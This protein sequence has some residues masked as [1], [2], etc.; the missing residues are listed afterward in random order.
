MKSASLWIWLAAALLAAVP[1]ARAETSRLWGRGGELWTPA[2]RLPD[3]SRAGYGAG[4]R[5]I[6]DVPVA[7]NVRDFGAAGDGL[8]D[9]S[10]AFQRALASAPA[11]ALLIPAGRYRLTT[12]L[13]VRRS[14]IVLRGEGPDRTVLYFPKPLSQV[15]KSA[16]G[17]SWSWS[18]AF[19]TFEGRDNGKPLAKLM[20]P[21]RRGERR[22]HVDAGSAVA[23]G[24]WVRLALTDPDGSLARH[25]QGGLPGGSRAYHGRVLVDFASR[26]AA[27][28]GDVVTLE[29]PLRTDVRLDW[30]P[31]LRRYRPSVREVGV[32]D[33]A[34][35]F[36]PGRY[37]GHHEEPGYN[38]VSFSGVSD[39][40]ARRLLIVNA[41][42]GVFFREGARFC[43]ARDVAFA[44]APGR[45]RAGYG[46]DLGE[47]R[48]RLVGGH[49][50][51]LATGLAQDNLVRDFSL[52]LRFVH[53][54]SVSAWAAGN[55]FARG[56]GVDLALDHH[57]RGPYENLFTDLDAG[58]GGRLWQSGGDRGD[59]PPS[60]ARETFWGIRS[61]RA[62]ELPPWA[63]DGN[64]VGLNSRTPARFS[65]TGDWWEPI[66]PAALEPADLYGAQRALAR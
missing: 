61:V 33:L 24:S 51:L 15:E 40:W 63:V 65:G 47:P 39:G 36:P 27:V 34:V 54:V 58:E 41:D 45:L 26:V 42:G 66:A 35:E 30:L 8:A 29:R 21:A 46:R 7:A 43:T 18:G 38:A 56:R 55:V 53:D 25:I 62:Q 1:A 17:G 12:V 6:P 3:F 64:F 50:A 28:E 9:D 10:A 20:A 37:A 48:R 23:P 52:E 13:R 31:E 22:L 11:G 19:I 2:G 14:G 57:R 49:H 4:R 44:A 60:G 32:E 5:E 16:P 59:G